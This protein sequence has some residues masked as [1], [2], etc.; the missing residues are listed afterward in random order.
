LDVHQNVVGRLLCRNHLAIDQDGKVYSCLR[1]LQERIA[2]IGGLNGGYNPR[3]L[4]E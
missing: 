4:E 1:G 3:R 2:P